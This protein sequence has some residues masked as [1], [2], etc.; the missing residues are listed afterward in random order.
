MYIENLQQKVVLKILIIRI[1]I[2]CSINLNAIFKMQ[3]ILLKYSTK[4]ECIITFTKT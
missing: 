4:F 3:K 2:Y 1:N